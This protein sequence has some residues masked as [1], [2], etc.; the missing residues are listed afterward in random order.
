[1]LR[2]TNWQTCCTSACHLLRMN[3]SGDTLALQRASV[4]PPCQPPPRVRRWPQVIVLMPKY[5]DKRITVLI[6]AIAV[7]TYCT[8]SHA[9]PCEPCCTCYSP[10]GPTWVV[11]S[12]CSALPGR[13]GLVQMA[14]RFSKAIRD[15]D[16]MMSTARVYADVNVNR[17]KDYWD[18]ENLSIEW[19]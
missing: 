14:Q 19:G 6:C 2:L 9:C 10:A 7:A 18:Y 8:I 5:K 11:Q 16:G 1:M 15:K 3:S 4:S 12:T 17:S 13:R